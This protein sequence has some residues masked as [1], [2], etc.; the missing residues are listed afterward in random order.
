[1]FFCNYRVSL[2]FLVL[3]EAPHKPHIRWRKCDG[4]AYLHEA[5]NGFLSFEAVTRKHSGCY[6][7]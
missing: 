5:A 7:S 4:D 1:M 2:N 3:L 6:E